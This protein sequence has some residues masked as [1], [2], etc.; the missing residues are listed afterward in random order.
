MGVLSDKGSE[1][2]YSQLARIIQE[3]ITSGKYRTDD[4]IPTEFE[5]SDMYQVSRSTVR[6]AVASLV[7]KGV[8]VKVHGRGTF[9][10]KPKIRHQTS[11]FLSATTGASLMGKRLDTQLLFNGW[12]TPT[13]KERDFFGLGKKD[14]VV[15][16][17]RLGLVGGN[18]V[19]IEKIR[20]GPAYAA[21]LEDYSEGSL[22]K[23]LEEK[24][25]IF[26]KDGTK[27]FEIC[28]A[29][30]EETELL[31]I[32]RGTALMLI[33]DNVFDQNGQPLHITKRVYRGDM[34]KYGISADDAGFGGNNPPT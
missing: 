18:P 27:T 12:D 10:G 26:P 30:L 25:G 6:K 34:L 13:D 3:E 1:P 11:G 15:Y 22:Y 5:L 4:Q 21:L 14:R 9:V 2:L 19:S 29:T 32:P 28:Y 7:D 16:L 31:Q 23:L 8:L 17:H 33:E 20:F 24:Y